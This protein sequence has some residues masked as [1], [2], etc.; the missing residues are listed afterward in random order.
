MWQYFFIFPKGKINRIH[1]W[2]SVGDRIFPP[3][4]STVPVVNKACQV[5]HW[6]GGPKGL[7]VPVPHV[8]PMIKYF[9]SHTI[10]I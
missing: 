9:F 3:R 8:S 6:N 4:G 7:D 1:Y 2:C 10:Q 5:S